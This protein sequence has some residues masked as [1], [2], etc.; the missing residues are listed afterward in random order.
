MKNPET[1]LD[2]LSREE[3]GIDPAELG[4]SPGVAA[5]TSLLLFAIGALVP[6]AP[7]FFVGG[8]AAT[9]V[10]ALAGAAGLFAIGAAI[11]LFTGRSVWVSGARQLGLGAAAAG[12]TFGIGKVI[13]VVA[14]G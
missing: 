7:Y 13:G 12:L 3:L 8:R 14:G 5:L 9:I 1:A 2:A 4:G 11:T 10:S 6:L